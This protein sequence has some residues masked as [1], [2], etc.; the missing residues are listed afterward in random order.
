MSVI[1]NIVPPPKNIGIPKILHQIWIGTRPVPYVW[2]DTWKEFCKKYGWKHMLWTNKEVAEFK[3]KNQASFDKS[4]SYQK[5]SDILRYEIMYKYGGMYLDADMIWLGKDL[6]KYMPFTTSNFIG[7]QEPFSEMYSVLGR[8]YLANGFF[9]CSKNHVIMKKCIRF[10]PARDKKYNKTFISTGPGLL[11]SAVQD[12]P[13]T[14]LPENWVFPVSFKNLST[15]D[16]NLYMKKSLIFTKSGYE[17][18]EK[19]D[20]KKLPEIVKLYF[21]RIAFM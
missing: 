4:V 5:K 6:G 9:C 2:T 3:L 17:L 10:L 11:N 13:I 20:F 16:Y 19:I 8:P 14:L 1:K 18:P 15:G 7:V 21:Y 12:Y